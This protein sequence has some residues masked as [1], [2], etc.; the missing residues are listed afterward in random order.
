MLA[1]FGK[2]LRGAAA[3][4]VV[5]ALSVA[6]VTGCTSDR[7]ADTPPA[8]ASGTRG[9]TVAPSRGGPEATPPGPPV[10]PG[11]PGS[12]GAPG[13]SPASGKP[14]YAPDFCK[15]K[16]IDGSVHQV[17]Q[18]NGGEVQ[19]NGLR[20]VGARETQLTCGPDVDNGGYFEALEPLG[21]Y[22]VA[23][24]ATVRLLASD[25]AT[26]RLV[27]KSADWRTLLELL[28]EC[29]KGQA[30]GPYVCSPFFYVTIDDEKGGVITDF[31]ALFQS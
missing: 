4:P 28:R 18:V 9:P 11:T 19:P 17:L 14:H 29:R 25:P 30:S 6:A 13:A 16:L 1:W 8:T 3:S 12:S 24:N 10:P 23:A 26:H 22:Y 21:P 20:V 31:T 15:E 27:L 2:R 7:A 5:L